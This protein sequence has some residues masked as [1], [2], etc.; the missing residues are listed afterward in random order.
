VRGL[1]GAPTFLEEGPSVEK[2]VACQSFSA[3]EATKTDLV[4]PKDSVR[5]KSKGEDDGVTIPKVSLSS[6]GGHFEASNTKQWRRLERVECGKKVGDSKTSRLTGKKGYAEVEQEEQLINHPN[7]E[8]RYASNN[9]AGF[10]LEVEV[11]EQP[12][13]SHESAMLELSRDWD[14]S[15][16][17]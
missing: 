3:P 15:H 6:G 10:S 5:R 11:T 17:L 12:A 8:L 4:N 16:S 9:L 1:A 13:L 14:P 7:K 2:Y